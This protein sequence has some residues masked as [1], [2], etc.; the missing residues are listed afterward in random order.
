[1]NNILLLLTILFAN[2]F[3][4]DTYM[5]PNDFKQSLVTAHRGSSY[6]APENTLS[7]LK[8]AIED[9]AGFAELD[10][11]ETK[12]GVIVVMH[13]NNA[14]R[15][16]GIN[17]AMWEIQSSELFRANAGAWFSHNFE[18]E[19]V[20]TLEQAIQTAKGKIKLN[21]ELKNNGHSK[22]LAEGTVKIIEKNQFVNQCVIS[23]FDPV[24]LK[25]VKK[26]NP[27]IKTA[28]IVG[29]E[30]DLDEELYKSRDYEAISISYLLIDQNVMRAAAAGNKEVYAWTVN[31]KDA[32]VKMIELGVN[33]ILTNHPDRLLQL[34]L[35]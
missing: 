27:N 23:S 31:D 5:S 24:L 6:T 17:K 3:T 8:K 7:A 32:M 15:T 2:N 10:V 9:G 14:F 21:I 4:S 25:K 34:L 18:D 22:H 33:S 29:R 1:M 13:D 35:A 12:D 16:T 20:P 28:L 30:K 19:K 11:Q 26:L